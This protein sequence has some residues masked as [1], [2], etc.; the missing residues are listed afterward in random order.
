MTTPIDEIELRIQKVGQELGLGAF[1]RSRLAVEQ[2]DA[3]WGGLLV[4][5][6]TDVLVR[7]GEEETELLSFAVPAT[8][9]QHLKQDVFPAWLLR[10]FPVRTTTLERRIRY[11][12]DATYP[13][14][15]VVL[16]KEY[17]PAVLRVRKLEDV[18]CRVP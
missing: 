12:I 1:S 2:A 9:W 16:P 14:A 18:C 6:V 13:Q 17:G 4:R 5:F 7:P 8:W 3:L 11:R 10:R 15:D